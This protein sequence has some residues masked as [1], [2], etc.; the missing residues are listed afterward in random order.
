MSLVLSHF[1]C[2]KPL[3][4][5]LSPSPCDDMLCTCRK[6]AE[7][8]CPYVDSVVFTSM[9][10]RH[11]RACC[12]AVLQK[13]GG[14][15]TRL[16][17]TSSAVVQVTFSSTHTTHTT[18]TPHTHIHTPHTHTHT[19]HTHSPP[20]HITHT[21]HTNTHHHATH[22]THTSYTHHTHTNKGL[23]LYVVM[24]RLSNHQIPRIGY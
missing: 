5:I 8:L 7:V 3:P 4:F 17:P 12:E 10:L 22:T 2:H 13:G 20:T 9:C 1:P 14:L 21:H 11:P 23:Q 6:I 19:H 16:S 15:R 24:E 18:H